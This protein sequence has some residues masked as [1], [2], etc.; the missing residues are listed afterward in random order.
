MTRS[1]ILVL[2][3]LCLAP[4]ARG[5]VVPDPNRGLYAIWTKPEISDRLPFLKGGQVVLQ[6][7]SVEPAEGRYDFSD[8]HRQLERIAKLGRVTTVQLN[9]NRQPEFLWNKVPGVSKTLTKEQDR[10][11]TLQ[12]WHPAYVKSYTDL[13][14]V[15]AREVKSSPYRSRVIGVRLNYNA[16]GTEFMIVSPQERDTTAWTT[17]WT[18]EI[19]ATYRKTIVDAFLRNFGPEIRMLLRTGNP[20]YPAPDAEALR[21]AGT[22]KLGFF[23]TA[24]EIEPRMPT[25]FDGSDPVF[26]EYCRPGKTVCYAESMADATGKHGPTQDPRWCPPVQYNYWRLLSDLNLGVSMI[27][28]YGADLANADQAEYRAAFDFAARYAGYH[29]SPSVSPGAWVALREGGL[30]LKGDYSFLM[31]RLPG[32][33]MKPEQKIGPDDQRFGAWTCTLPKGA[34]AKFALD[35]EFAR[36]LANKKAMLRVTYLDGSHGSFT[37]HA[38]GRTFHCKLDGSGRWKTAEFEVASVSFPPDIVIEGDSDLT[39]HMIEVAF[40]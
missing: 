25:M 17:P 28:V 40:K 2:V 23:T 31:R 6:W 16:I 14:A 12:Y 13:I 10:R 9:A 22:G 15:F 24:S 36:S 38:A 5:E 1:G 30:K 18:E 35:S 21:L 37:A 7:E 19:A 26:L 32:A 11:G 29:A 4:M 39:L 20:Q 3:L 33:A 27:G 8:M 34:Q